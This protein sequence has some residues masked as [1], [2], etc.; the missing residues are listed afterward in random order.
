MFPLYCTI[1]SSEISSLRVDKVT[2]L[3]Q[4]NEM[5]K[6]LDDL[7]SHAGQKTSEIEQIQYEISRKRQEIDEI[8]GAKEA[9]KAR[10]EVATS[11][12]NA[13]EKVYKDEAVRR[14][15]D[16]LKEN[17]N[18]IG[19]GEDEREEIDELMGLARRNV[20]V[21]VVIRKAVWEVYF[22]TKTKEMCDR[23]YAKSGYKGKVSGIYKIVNVKT[24]ECYVGQ[25]VDIGAR[26]IT[27]V[28]RALGVETET[29][30]RLYPN[31]RQYG[32]ENFR[33]SVLEV[34]DRLN[35]R[36]K[37]WI[38]MFGSELNVKKG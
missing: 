29:N 9:A 30:N 12:L 8:E 38:D 37:Y 23:V 26:W 4:L 11:N 6:R 36:E 2:H 7:A 20:K 17:Y 34:T 32:V 24:G 35:E 31:M 15:E 16:L 33:F 28:K 1:N 21:G 25:A 3:E 14:Q 5:R 13:A 19:L 22:R 10:L 18:R 27:H